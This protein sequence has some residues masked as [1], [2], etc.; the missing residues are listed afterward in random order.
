M[1]SAKKRIATFL[2]VAVYAISLLLGIAY[3]LSNDILEAFAKT[4]DSTY[5]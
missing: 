1:N 2:L 3:F 4:D 5:A